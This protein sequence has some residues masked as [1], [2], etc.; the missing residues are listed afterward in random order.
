MGW[1]SWGDI[2]RSFTTGTV[3][4]RHSLW[5]IQNEWSIRLATCLQKENAE[6]IN[7]KLLS[8]VGKKTGVNQVH[9]PIS[10]C[11]SFRNTWTVIVSCRPCCPGL[12]SCI[13]R[14]YISNKEVREKAFGA[15]RSLHQRSSNEIP[16]P[17]KQI[18]S[19]TV[20]SVDN[21]IYCLQLVYSNCTW[22]HSMCNY[23]SCLYEATT[24]SK[25]II[26]LYE[27]WADSLCLSLRNAQLPVFWNQFEQN[28]NKVLFPL[29]KWLSG[30]M[31]GKGSRWVQQRS[32]RSFKR[33]Q[34]LDTITLATQNRLSTNNWHSALQM[35]GGLVTV[36][37]ARNTSS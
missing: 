25:L 3:H 33:D 12:F 34:L 10:R 20:I 28:S 5:P 30:A 18:W 17:E 16:M 22:K 36:E 29:Q 9:Q 13:R 2:K 32:P 19:V 24:N 31:S 26:T 8:I 4:F 21:S 7:N 14:P 27:K 11:F 6:I 15:G 35:L 37:I 1:N 23:S